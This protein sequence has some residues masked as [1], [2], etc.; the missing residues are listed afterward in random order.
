M[1]GIY[2]YIIYNIYIYAYLSGL[3]RFN[4]AFVFFSYIIK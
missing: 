4:V 1:Q 3:T 2:N